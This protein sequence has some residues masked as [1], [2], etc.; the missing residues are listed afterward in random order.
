MI[1]ACRMFLAMG[2]AITVES[3]DAPGG[4]CWHCEEISRVDVEVPEGTLCDICE[5]PIVGEPA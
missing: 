5:E 4:A 1:K 2:E 3:D